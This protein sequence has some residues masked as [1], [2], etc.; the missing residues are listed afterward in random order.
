MGGE[1]EDRSEGLVTVG[2]LLVKT[3]P[4]MA[5]GTKGEAC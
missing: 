2:D 3:T 4:V 1:A 5:P